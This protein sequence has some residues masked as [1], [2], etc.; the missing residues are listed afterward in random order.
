[1]QFGEWRTDGDDSKEK[2]Q[3]D[4]AAASRI[5]GTPSPTQQPTQY[6]IQYETGDPAAVSKYYH[7]TISYPPKYPF[8]SIVHI[9]QNFAQDM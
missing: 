6:N 4:A 2:S 7:S 1:M 9:Y 5:V 3:E 8:P